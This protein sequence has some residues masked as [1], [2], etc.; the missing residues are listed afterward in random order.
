MVLTW[1][2]KNDDLYFDLH[3][4]T[5][6]AEAA[7]SFPSSGLKLINS[8]AHQKS[9]ACNRAFQSLD[10]EYQKTLCLEQFNTNNGIPR[11]FAYTHML[12]D[13]PSVHNHP[14]W[15]EATKSTKHMGRKKPI[16]HC[17]QT[18][19]ALQ[20]A[21]DHTFTGSYAKRFHPSDPPETH[22]CECGH[23]LRDPDHFIHK[24]P[25]LSQQRRDSHIQ[26]NFD[27]FSLRDVFNRHPDWL[28]AFL[29]HPSYIYAP[30][31]SSQH[32]ELMQE[33]QVEGIG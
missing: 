11:R 12:V 15:R 7:L 8:A 3:A 20:L 31:L 29:K 9:L 10:R 17:R 21:V 27:T 24:C 25:I 4:R 23:P 5:L 13:G 16:Y 19:T 6:A 22:S 28:F 32:P 18:S 14:L 30:P 26:T 2:P 33:E 1:S